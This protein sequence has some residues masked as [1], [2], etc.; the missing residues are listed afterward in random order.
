MNDI[1]KMINGDDKIV[2]TEQ[3]KQGRPVKAIKA[4]KKIATY[5]TA[6]EYQT[7]VELAEEFNKS[8]SQLLKEVVLKAII[9]L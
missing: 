4:D 6:S 1:E 9:D 2:Q 7:F 3:V 5:L 8:I